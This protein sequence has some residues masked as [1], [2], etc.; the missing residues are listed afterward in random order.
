MVDIALLPVY[1]TGSMSGPFSLIWN[2]V[3]AYDDR[4]TEFTDNRFYTML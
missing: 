1:V 4:I 3:L 2:T